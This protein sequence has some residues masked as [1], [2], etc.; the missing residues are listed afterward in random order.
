MVRLNWRLKQS[1]DATLSLQT[2]Y[3]APS[4]HSLLLLPRMI[5]TAEKYGTHPRLVI[6]SSSAAFS[7]KLDKSVIHESSPLRLI[8][9]KKWLS[10]PEYATTS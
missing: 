9:S 10:N 8:G 3:I 6:V 4:L 1:I 2:N 7:A 5:E